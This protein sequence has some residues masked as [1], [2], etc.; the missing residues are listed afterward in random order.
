MASN[1]VI[2]DYQPFQCVKSFFMIYFKNRFT[3]KK[4]SE[5]VQAKRED[6][7]RKRRKKNEEFRIDFMPLCMDE[8]LQAMSD[9]YQEK[10]KKKD[11]LD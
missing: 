1:W 3:L 10:N 7:L 4:H 2:S 8:D 5:K 6:I 11:N 9:F